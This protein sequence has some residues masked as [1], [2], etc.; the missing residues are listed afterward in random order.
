MK[1]EILRFG[2]TICTRL[3]AKIKITTYSFGPH[4]FG[5]SGPEAEEGC[6]YLV[7]CLHMFMFLQ[8]VLRV[9]ASDSLRDGSSKVI[10]VHFNGF[11][12]YMR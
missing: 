1:N 10:D 8:R 12:L 4:K 2:D 7:L 5:R 3:P 9:E 6:N 11:S